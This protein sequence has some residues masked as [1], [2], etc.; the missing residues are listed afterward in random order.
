VGLARRERAIKSGGR[1]SEHPFES[2]DVNDVD[3]DP[4]DH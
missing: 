1:P 3:T 4:D 2:F